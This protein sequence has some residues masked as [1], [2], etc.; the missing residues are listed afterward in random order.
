M[1]TGSQI[2]SQIRPSGVNLYS[3]TLSSPFCDRSPILLALGGGHSIVLA[4]APPVL[5][6]SG[7]LNSGAGG[8]PVFTP[9]ASSGSVLTVVHV[10]SL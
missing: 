3:L 1:G 9:S 5:G 4:V 2:V 7:L 6:G 8:S 10:S